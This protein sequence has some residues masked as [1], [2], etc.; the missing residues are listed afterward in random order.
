VQHPLLISTFSLIN[1]HGILHPAPAERGC[2]LLPGRYPVKR[3][4][5]SP[6]SETQL[7]SCSYDMTV[8]LWDFQAP[9][10]ALLRSWDHHTEF[11]VGC[12]ISTLQARLL[13]RHLH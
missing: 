1:C 5:F 3:V 9:E 13:S 4:L 6:H 7:L 10:D 8:K 2:M 12:D 11:V